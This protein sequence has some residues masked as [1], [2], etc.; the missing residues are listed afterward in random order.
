MV[1]V[2][3]VNLVDQFSGLSDYWDAPYGGAT[4]AGGY[5]HIPCGHTGGSP[6]YA[7]LL[8]TRPA[9]GNTWTIG[10]S[11]AHVE[12][13]NAPSGAG[14]TVCYAQLTI[15]SPTAGTYLSVLYDAVGGYLSFGIYSA[16]SDP[17]LVVITYVPASHR[18]WRISHGSGRIYWQTSPDA[19][20]WTTQRTLTGPPSWIITQECRP[21]LDSTRN[22]GLN[23]YADFDN[24]NATTTTTINRTVTTTAVVG[25]VSVNTTT[26]S[27]SALSAPPVVAVTGVIPPPVVSGGA[28]TI[29]LTV[30]GSV[31]VPTV[32]MS[33]SAVLTQVP[34]LAQAT[35]PIPALST[36]STFLP[37][38][39]RGVVGIPAPV[40]RGGTTTVPGTVGGAVGI[41]LPTIVTGLSQL[42][43]PPSI[44]FVRYPVATFEFATLRMPMVGGSALMVTLSGSAVVRTVSGSAI[45]V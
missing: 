15:L 17:G 32:S 34:V 27:G 45:V 8:S 19:S 2:P 14:A 41:P 20:T 36:G 33:T 29:P 6:N 25:A 16:W 37:V 7:G 1:A 26:T 40:I 18:W 10:S 13:V 21:Q 44:V 24:F 30:V 9:T 11:Q 23:D 4:A 42:F 38:R 12:L 5:A 43:A 39:V 22:G 28:L 3:L 31:A 35:V